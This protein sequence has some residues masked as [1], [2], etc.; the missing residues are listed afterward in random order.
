[1]A[2]NI[3]IVHGV[4]GSSRTFMGEESA[5]VDSVRI[6]H[7][8][9][10]A[11]QSQLALAGGANNA[12]RWDILLPY[13][14]GRTLTHDKHTHVW[15][16]LAAGAGMEFGSM[17][18]FVVL[19]EKQHALDR[20][21]KPI[22]RLV[23][24]ESDQIRRTPGAITETLE[25]MWSGMA[26]KVKP[27]TAAILS[28]AS[29]IA[30]VTEEERAFLARHPGLAVRATGTHLGHA[31]ESQFPANI[32]LAAAAIQ[33]GKLYP[34]CDGSG[35]ERP[36]DAPLRQVVVTSVGHRRGESLALVEA[37]E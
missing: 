8:R 1:M 23:A 19:E 9:I 10:A 35:V 3:S 27:E 21:A 30:I 2:G 36:M 28:G 22:A 13:A 18:A 29:G 11:G 32:A 20:G 12:E 37:V 6:A 15:E 34:A 33:R 4:T 17:A 26:A 31:P 25:R 7:A 24:I 14:L 16:R 5:G